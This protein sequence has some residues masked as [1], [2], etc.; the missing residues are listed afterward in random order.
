MAAFVSLAALGAPSGP[1]ARADWVVG[2]PVL[3]GEVAFKIDELGGGG[4]PCEP[5][6]NVSGALGDV[7]KGIVIEDAI[8]IACPGTLVSVSA[9]S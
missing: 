1:S 7:G 3:T 9:I 2:D 6:V 5:S 4:T 8:S